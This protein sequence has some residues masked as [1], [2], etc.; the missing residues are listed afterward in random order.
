MSKRMD[1]PYRSG[2][3]KTWL[4]SKNPASEAVRREREEEWLTCNP[5]CYLAGRFRLR[6]TYR[7]ALSATGLVFGSPH[8][9]F[10]LH[11]ELFQIP[12]RRAATSLPEFSRACPDIFFGPSRSQTELEPLFQSINC[13]RR[14]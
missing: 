7:A 13:L 5:C 9:S 2:P 4:K 12:V 11:P 14:W 3:S 1:A 8:F 6:E 10:C